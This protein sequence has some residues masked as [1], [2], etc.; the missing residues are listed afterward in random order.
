MVEV[1]RDGLLFC[2]CCLFAAVNGDACHCGVSA[3]EEQRG[4]AAHDLRVTAGLSDLGT[5]GHVVPDF[6][7]DTGDG[8]D[9]FSW[10]SCDCCNT[11]LGG[12]RHRFAVLGAS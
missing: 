6:D 12:S 2:E 1:I 4:A 5:I 9:E 7:S 11:R 8:I 10:R 3:E